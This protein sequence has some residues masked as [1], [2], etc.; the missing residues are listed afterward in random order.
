MFKDKLKDLRKSKNYT[1]DDLANELNI[2]RQSISKW[3]TG[4]AYPTKP[5]AEALCK[6]FD[7][8]MNQ[9]LEPD[10]VMWLS[11]DNNSKVKDI[12]KRT[13]LI[14]IAVFV[15]I[16]SIIG[17]L[18][19]LNQR[20][21]QFEPV[22]ETPEIIEPLVGFIVLDEA[23]SSAYEA[24]PSKLLAMIESK[25]YPYDL[26]MKHK[27]HAYLESNRLFETFNTVSQNKVQMTATVIFNRDSDEII[28]VYSIFWDVASETY[29][30]DDPSSVRFSMDISVNYTIQGQ[31]TEAHP[32]DTRYDITLRTSDAL[33]SVE[34]A[35]YDATNQFIQTRLL[36]P[37][38]HID[39]D[40]DTLN[41]VITE[42]FMDKNNDTYIR[43]APGM[44]PSQ[45]NAYYYT[46]IEFDDS[47]F[48]KPKTIMIGTKI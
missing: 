17:I 47:L 46:Y 7:V 36:T 3:E 29:Y 40:K 45:T 37:D 15:V 10:E 28:S 16:I 31:K 2:S 9:L 42:T 38:V 20:I 25:I 21:N 41:F 43:K 44:F 24:D 1:Q 39:F 18:F 35:E 12:H 4:V 13:K 8:Q 11:I 34:L 23:G 26:Y 14:F 32:Y 33:V 48:A 30:L 5:M 22:L 27:T 19:W 6:L